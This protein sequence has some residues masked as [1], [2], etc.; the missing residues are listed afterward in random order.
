MTKPFLYRNEAKLNGFLIVLAIVFTFF[1]VK[2]SANPISEKGVLDLREWDFEKDGT[3]D[4]KGEW[5]FYWQKFLDHGSIAE[6]EPSTFINSPGMWRQGEINGVPI[7]RIGYGT[8]QLRVLMGKR[9][10]NLMLEIPGIYTAYELDVNGKTKATRGIIGKTEMLSEPQFGTQTPIIYSDTSTLDIII[11]ISDFDRGS[12][13][14]NL[15]ISI[16]TMEDILFQDKFQMIVE[17]FLVGILFFCFL[18]HIGLFLLRRK[19]LHLLFF[20]LFCLAFVLRLL[21]R[22]QKFLFDLFPIEWW[23]LFNRIEFISLFVIPAFYLIY[24][25]QLFKKS[26][27]QNVLRYYIGFVIFQSV[28]TLFLPSYWHSYLLPL[29]QFAGAMVGLYMT[30]ISYNLVRKGNRIARIFLIGHGILL[31]GIAHDI[32]HF[33]YVFRSIEILGYF[34]IIFIFLQIY[35]LA[36]NSSQAFSRVEELSRSLNEKVYERTEQLKKA[37]IVKGKMLS[38][39]SHDLRSPLASLDGYLKVFDNGGIKEEEQSKVLKKLRKSLSESTE[40][41]DNLLNWASGQLESNQLV[42]HMEDLNLHNVAEESIEL[43]NEQIAEKNVMVK[44]FIAEN[45]IIHADRNMIKS[46]IRN[47][48]SN[49]IKFTPDGGTIRITSKSDLKRMVVSVIDSGIGLPDEIKDKLFTITPSSSRMGTQSEKGVGVGLVLCK[50]FVTQM[51]GEIWVENRNG[52]SK[53]T[54]FSFSLPIR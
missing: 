26:I 29:Y 20:A 21:T 12:G 3:L 30:V 48:V 18:Y 4:L 2:L 44:N 27:N 34:S 50:D 41:L 54:V 7:P 8:M 42:A 47:L 39:I 19:D 13:G 45:T 52:G 15:P 1:P 36:R 10:H 6:H 22:G 46:V 25:N 33:N 11:R 24:F 16:G 31:F 14:I 37:N 38:V 43:F 17:W 51:G 23:M 9:P 35:A 28:M 40:L 5:A 53:G 32:M 49:A